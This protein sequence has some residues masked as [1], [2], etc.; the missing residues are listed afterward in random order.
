M[1]TETVMISDCVSATVLRS[2]DTVVEVMV[3]IVDGL[4]VQRRG[5]P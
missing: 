5:T 4:R 1:T 2:S 3:M